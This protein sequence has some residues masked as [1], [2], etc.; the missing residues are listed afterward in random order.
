MQIANLEKSSPCATLIVQR[1]E[2][3]IRIRTNEETSLKSSLA[4]SLLAPN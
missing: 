3:R 1:E 2:I 4:A